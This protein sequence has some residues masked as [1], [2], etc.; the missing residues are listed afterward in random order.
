MP[1]DVF[2]SHSSKDKV[3]ADAVCARL[4][5]EGIRC[6]IAPRDILPGVSW[7]SA[8]VEAI[9]G[10]RLMVL[11]FSS[12]ANASPQI[13]R[14]VERALNKEVPI[15]PLRIESVL[16]GKNLEYFLG[17]PHWLDAL[18]PPFEQYLEYIA[19]TVKAL[20]QHGKTGEA[21]DLPHPPAPS[22]PAP[23]PPAPPRKLGAWMV[24][25]AAAVGLVVVVALGWW[26]LQGGAV[27]RK[28]TGAWTTSNFVG[29]DKIQFTLQVGSGGHYRY[30]VLYK[31]S[32]KVRISGGQTYLR[33]ADGLE[34]PAGPVASGSNPPIPANL[35]AAAPTGVWPLIYRF[36]NTTKPLPP[37]NPFLLV[38]PGNPGTGRSGQPAIWE[39]DAAFGPVAWQ[40]RF[41]FDYDGGFSF[42]AHAVDVGRFYAHDGKWKAT[43]DVLETQREGA[44]SF[45]GDNSMVL[46]GSIRGAVA[47]SEMGNT[48][49]ERLGTTQAAPTAAA[50]PLTA[51]AAAS[52]IASPTAASATS[53]AA[54]SSSP[55]AT[56]PPPPI[57]AL[58][59]HFL[60]SHDSPVYAG[61][62][63]SSAVVGQVR[64][65]RYVHITGLTGNWLRVRL[66]D[67]TV[68]FIPD[69]AVE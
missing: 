42:T 23:Q 7:G 15:V 62:D 2:I 19:Q 35:V 44:Y 28:F 57:M 60:I 61:P 63:S 36:S 29:P 6:W 59:R 21:I 3:Y 17:T 53:T 9:E 34:R 24:G 8:I 49:W 41:L 20:L 1:H 65:G 5:S 33:T 4:E 43:S 46:T 54:P 50:S 26:L 32:G 16:P 45:V 11:V 66:Y 52:V 37:V 69:Q 38:Q 30:E 39:W 68:G 27:P 56:P 22:S 48:L 55:T 64:R 31:E 14:E 13:E 40:I 51:A 12:H 18:T 58:D 10:A 25:A 47:T 67:G